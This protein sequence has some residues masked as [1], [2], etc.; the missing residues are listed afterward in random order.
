MLNL[1]IAHQPL[2]HIFSTPPLCALLAS[3]PRW[4]AICR[5]SAPTPHDIRP[6]FGNCWK[7]CACSPYRP[8]REGLRLRVPEDGREREREPALWACCDAWGMVEGACLYKIRRSGTQ[9]CT[10]YVLSRCPPSIWRRP[11]TR[12]CIRRLKY[13]YSR[14]H[15]T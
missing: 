6:I 3:N 13:I 2:T 8:Y 12:Y 14:W 1:P 10:Q 7:H 4:L 5:V 11:F 9:P 15:H